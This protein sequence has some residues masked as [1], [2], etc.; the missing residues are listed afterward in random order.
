MCYLC[1]IV[2]IKLPPYL[3][4]IVLALQWLQRNPGRTFLQEPFT[5]IQPIENSIYSIYDPLGIKLL[6]ILRLVFCHL[7]KHKF[8][9][10]FA[11]TVNP[12]S[13]KIE[14]ITSPFA[15]TL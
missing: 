5:F 7:H 6:N 15:Q 11:D 3:Y 10:N 8:R 14:S 12:C 13:L 2:S 4:E 9:Y 1:K